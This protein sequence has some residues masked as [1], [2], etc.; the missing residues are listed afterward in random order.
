MNHPQNPIL[1]RK[2]HSA[3]IRLRRFLKSQR[4]GFSPDDIY[5]DKFFD[6]PGFA[7]TDLA[8]VEIARY[9]S[10]TYN[11]GSVLDI[12]CGTGR[13][14]NAFAAPGRLVVGCDGSAAGV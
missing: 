1:L 13:Y 14:L 8:A 6:G 3:G 2:V 4:F 9:L 10:A 11:P 12:G 5:D 7:S